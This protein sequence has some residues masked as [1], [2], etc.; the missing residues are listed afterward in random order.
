MASGRFVRVARAVVADVTPLRVSPAYRRLW[1][2]L[3]VSNIGQQMTAVAVAWQVYDLSNDPAALSL[4]YF[5]A[6]GNAAGNAANPGVG[7]AF[8]AG[9]GGGAAGGGVVVPLDTLA[10][11]TQV[12]GPQTVC[13]DLA[14]GGSA[15]AFLGWATRQGC[16]RALQGWGMLV[17]QAAESFRVWRG[18]R[19]D[20]A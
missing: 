16:A 8:A 1:L 2:G 12:I 18:I 15:T 19:P 13:Y 17:E 5:K 10:K 11:A 3:G 14:Y 9:A 20:T 6:A 7:G 4:L